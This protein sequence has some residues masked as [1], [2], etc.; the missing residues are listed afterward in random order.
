MLDAKCRDTQALLGG[1]EE[2]VQLDLAS[3]LT[4]KEE[5]IWCSYLVKTSASGSSEDRCNLAHTLGK[6]MSSKQQTGTPVLL[7]LKDSWPAL[8]QFSNSSLFLI[9]SF[10][11]FLTTLLPGPYQSGAKG[12][13]SV[14]Q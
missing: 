5:D 1:P 13:E 8:N 14:A 4:R 6:F 9:K 12:V 7:E 11:A 3:L 10:Q 2:R